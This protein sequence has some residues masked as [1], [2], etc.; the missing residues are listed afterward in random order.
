MRING[1]P[2]VYQIAQMIKIEQERRILDYQQ[3]QLEKDMAVE[4]NQ[5]IRKPEDSPRK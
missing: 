4:K 2:N 1:T 5:E 3:R